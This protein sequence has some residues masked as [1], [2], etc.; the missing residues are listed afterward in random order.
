MRFPWLAIAALLAAPGVA[1]P[2][3]PADIRTA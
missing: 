1:D 3:E 2:A